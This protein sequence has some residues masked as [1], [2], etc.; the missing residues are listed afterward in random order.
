MSSFA[1]HAVCKRNFALK[2]V[3][4]AVLF[5]IPLLFNT[6]TSAASVAPDVGVVAVAPGAGVVAQGAGVVA[7]VAGDAGAAVSASLT[8]SDVLVDGIPVPVEA[9]N[10]SNY[11]YFKL[12]DLAAAVDCAVWY[13]DAS[14]SVHIDSS[15]FYVHPD[16]GEAYS[17]DE[18]EPL[19]SF[20]PLDTLQV[21]PASSTII[22]NGNAASLEAYNIGGYNYFKLRD[23]LS[24]VNIGVWYNVTT[25]TIHIETDKDYE[26]N[27]RG[28]AEN[29]I[30]DINSPAAVPA[31]AVDATDA[32]GDADAGDAGAGGIDETDITSLEKM[33]WT[34]RMQIVDLINDERAAVGVSPLETA[35]ILFE[36]AQFKCED[37]AANDYFDHVSPIHGDLEAL[38][39][40]FG[41]DF[42]IIGENIAMGHMTP[43]HVM[44][45][46]MDSKGHR[47][48]ILDPDYE[49]IGVGLAFDEFG[50]TYWSQT[51][52]RY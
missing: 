45:D 28:P 23:F 18:F 24:A 29:A 19:N 7:S 36:I 51:F 14:D 33:A 38:F 41:I 34:F 15:G 26:P 1:D 43:R 8:T 37:M 5:I 39:N 32:A 12:R 47:D 16:G 27:Y 6:G 10:L 49:Y 50:T 40:Q 44:R 13:D 35:D 48:N 42:H 31:G 46:W 2:S 20:D 3:F 25:D 52:L 11:N 22:I 9:Y 21:L 30:L 4:L 17:E